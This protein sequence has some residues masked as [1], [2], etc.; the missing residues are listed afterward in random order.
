M[1]HYTDNKPGITWQILSA[2]G[3]LR[4]YAHD[5]Y[6]Y[7][8]VYGVSIKDQPVWSGHFRGEQ[9]V[10]YAYHWLVRND[11]SVVRLLDDRYIGWHAGNKNINFRSVAIVLDGQFA[12]SEPSASAVEGIASILK[13]YYPQ[14]RPTGVIGH[15]EANSQTDCPGKLF[16]PVWKEKILAR[17]H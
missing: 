7:D 5:Y 4:Q 3:L 13:K 6:Q 9:Q 2:I 10:F 11:G 1:I 14:I 8:D 15:S 17:L 12:E 16:L